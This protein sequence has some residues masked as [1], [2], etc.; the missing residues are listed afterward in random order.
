[1]AREKLFRPLEAVLPQARDADY[2]G[3]SLASYR[4]GGHLWALP[5][6]G[7]TQVA[8]YRPDLFA[9]PPPADWDAVLALGRR[10]RARGRWLGL[11]GLNPHGFLV[12]AALAA[13]LGGA[14]GEDA[15]TPFPA[16]VLEEAL[17]RL[18]AAWALCHPD[19]LAANAIDLHEAMS[20]RDDIVYCPLAYGYLTYAE[21]DRRKP[22]RFADFPGP[23]APHAAGS[24]LG[25][26]GLGI[27][28][29]CRDVAMAERF[30]R[31]LADGAA[32]T[33]LIAAHHG[34]PG[35]SAAWN[36]PA[37]DE[38]MGGAFSATR[39]SMLGASLRPRFAGYVGFQHAA[40]AAVAAYLARDLERRA[41]C[42]ALGRLWREYRAARPVPETT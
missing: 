9:E 35:A 33:E 17:E 36:D 16:A 39:Q 8:L 41:L 19:G 18:D 38:R 24:V 20:D 31:L 11:A 12:L 29:S 6:D 10:L 26:T 2:I 23:R 34:Q 30:L 4:Y 32:Q 28:R 42:E 21:A 22:L 37:S 1:V 13:N 25:G 40:G 14:M 27:T 15:E 5:V 3:A 7:A